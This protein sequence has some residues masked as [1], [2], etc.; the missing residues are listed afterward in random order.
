VGLNKDVLPGVWPAL[1]FGSNVDDLVYLEGL[2]RSSGGCL[3]S[4]S[5]ELLYSECLRI[6]EE[7]Y[8]SK[9]LKI[10]LPYGLTATI[11]DTQLPEAWANILHVFCYRD[12]ARFEDFIPDHGWVVV[13]VGAYLGFYTLW[14]GVHV[15]DSGLVVAVEPNPTAREILLSNVSLNRGRIGRIAFDPR[16]VCGS[17]G[18]RRLYVTGYWATSSIVRSYAEHMGDIED[19]ILVPCTTLDELFED[20]NLEHIDLLKLDVEGAEEEVLATPTVCP[21]KVARIVVEVHPPWAKA[22]RLAKLL[23]SRGYRVDIIAPS[24]LEHQVFVYAIASNQHVQ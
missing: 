10:R 12:Y 16:L 13:D 7:G 14:A 6:L 4:E 5:I 2:K 23:H 19:T 15:G 1:A 24:E 3:P 17:P 20:H 8:T 22:E 21:K 11:P 9:M 18:I